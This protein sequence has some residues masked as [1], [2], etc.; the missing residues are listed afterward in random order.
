VNNLYMPLEMLFKA[1][2]FSTNAAL[3]IFNFFMNN[4]YVSQKISLLSKNFII[5]AVFK[6]F[7]FL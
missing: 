4:F 1:V 6:I 2:L 5:N 7:S 3:E